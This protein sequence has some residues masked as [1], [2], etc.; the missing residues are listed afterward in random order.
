M[1]THQNLDARE[2]R[3]KIVA[4]YFCCLHSTVQHVYMTMIRL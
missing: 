4:D 3:D 2:K 1:K